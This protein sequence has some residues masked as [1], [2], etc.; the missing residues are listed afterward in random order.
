MRDHRGAVELHGDLA[1]EWEVLV[2][3]ARPRT[4][5]DPAGDEITVRDTVLMLRKG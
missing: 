3:D 2:R 1:G 4:T 5:K